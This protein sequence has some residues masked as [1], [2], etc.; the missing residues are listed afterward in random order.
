MGCVNLKYFVCAD[1]SM[2]EGGELS[3]FIYIHH[4]YSPQWREQFPCAALCCVMADK[5]PTAAGVATRRQ[6]RVRGDKLRH[7]AVSHPAAAAGQGDASAVLVHGKAGHWWYRR[8]HW[9]SP[10]RHAVLGGLAGSRWCHVVAREWRSGQGSRLFQVTRVRTRGHRLQKWPVSLKRQKWL[11]IHKSITMKRTQIWAK[12]T[13]FTKKQCTNRN[14]YQCN[15]FSITK[16]A[17]KVLF[18]KPINVGLS[19][20]NINMDFGWSWH[21]CVNWQGYASKASEGCARCCG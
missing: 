8:W 12:F 5:G 21:P 6:R 17:Q 9:L 14:L 7:H 1:R 13:L 16:L 4:L 20:K 15:T 3:L 11:K 2:C 18:W 19:D 10:V